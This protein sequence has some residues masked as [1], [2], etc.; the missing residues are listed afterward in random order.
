MHPIHWLGLGVA[1]LAGCA[2]AEQHTPSFAYAT[3]LVAPPHRSTTADELPSSAQL[4]DYVNY[5]L[6]HRPELRASLARWRAARAEVDAVRQ[7]GDFEVGYGAL[8]VPWQHRVG[9]ERH[10]V[11]IAQ[12]FP[13]F[14]TVARDQRARAQAAAIGEVQFDQ[15]M[16]DIRW[17]VLD[18]YWQLWAVQQQ[19]AWHQQHEEIMRAVTHSIRGR[20]EVGKAS[21]ADVAR[22]E[23]ASSRTSNDEASTHHGHR[24]AAHAFAR[25]LG[26]DDVG[27]IPEITP[28]PPRV[29]ELSEDELVA[30]AATHPNV[31]YWAAQRTALNAERDALQS[32][33]APMLGVMLEWMEMGAADPNVAH[34][35]RDQLVGSVTVHVP[36]WTGELRA[37]A[38]AIDARIAASN[39]DEEV[40]RRDLEV[41]V[42]QALVDV[43][44][45]ARAVRLYEQTI[46]PQA[47][48][49]LGSV[50]GAY[51]VGEAD[52]SAL[53]LAS[54]ELL[55]VRLSL[56]ALR[57]EH[58]RA[59]AALERI[60]ATPI[61]SQ[62]AR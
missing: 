44:N 36:L 24:R 54:D 26:R 10:R 60:T 43:R 4:D 37:Q 50:R 62:V 14:G 20:V 32:R 23:L 6:R 22:A 47:E 27:H 2:T 28:P 8:L 3:E 51:E 45:T 30:H 35:G 42:R 48:A 49:M 58:E 21:V 59:W 9:H 1:L 29:P 38:D 52:A 15:A 46:V 5:A 12:T 39:A 61:T 17:Q 34:S 13:W 40:V 53:L 33:R 25:A 57:A 19:H 16:I 18:S 31:A 55:E 56:V 7:L 11:H 41:A